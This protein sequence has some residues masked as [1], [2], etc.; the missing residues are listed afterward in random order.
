MLTAALMEADRAQVVGRR[1][2]GRASIQDIL[3]TG[4]GTALRLT[5]ARFVQ[6][7]G[8]ALADQGLEPGFEVEAEADS[9]EEPSGD[10]VLDKALELLGPDERAK[11]A[12]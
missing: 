11:T 7:D 12:A 10:P 8:R 5:I 1:S 4:E 6:S 9:G 3:P 2:F